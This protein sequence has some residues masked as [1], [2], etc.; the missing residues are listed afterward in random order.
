MTGLEMVFTALAVLG[1]AA[2][3]WVTGIVGWR[4]LRSPRR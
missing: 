2:T 4:L 3:V 1:F